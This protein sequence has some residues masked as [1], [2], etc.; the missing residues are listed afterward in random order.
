MEPEYTLKVTHSEAMA[1]L[2]ALGELPAKHTRLAMNKVEAQIADQ[3]VAM[4]RQ[5]AEQMMEDS[6]G[7]KAR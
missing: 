7:E 6:K 4:Q 3:H 1:I 2:T 5:A